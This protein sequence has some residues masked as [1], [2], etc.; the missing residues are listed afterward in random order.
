MAYLNQASAQ[1][2]SKGKAIAKVRIQW[3][4]GN[5]LPDA[6]EVR[7][8]ADSVT[9]PVL[10]ASV[11]VNKSAK[12]PAF[13]EFE[14]PAPNVLS[15][16]V[17]PRTLSNNVLNDKMPDDAGF[18]QY[19]E[20]F[21]VQLTPL[22]L[23]AEGSA[24]PEKPPAPLVLPFDDIGPTHIGVHWQ[25][26]YNFDS[27]FINITE[28]ALPGQPPNAPRT[29]HHGDDGEWGFQRVD[30]LKPKTTYLV[31]VQ[32]CTKSFFGLLSNNCWEWS[33]VV[34]CTTR[35]ASSFAVRPPAGA[36]LAASQQYGIDDQTDVFVVDGTGAVNVFWVNG[37]RPWNGPYAITAPGA[38]PVGAKVV[39]SPQ[40]GVHGQTDVFFVDNNGAVNVLWV[41]AGGSWKGPQAISPSGFAPAGAALAVSRQFGLDQTDVFAVGNNGAIHVLWATGG[42]AWN[43]PVPIS[44]AGFAP[45]GAQLAASKQ[46]G[47]EQTVVFVIGNSGAVHVLWAG[48]SGPWAGPAPISPAGF[49]PP[50]GALAASQQFGLDQT[51]VFVA[52]NAGAVNVLWAGGG[53]AW[54]GPAALSPAGF[55]S[56]GAGITASQQFGAGAQTDVFVVGNNGAL[57]VLWVGGGGAWNGPAPLTPGGFAPAGAALA[58]SKQ[59]G[60]EQLDVFLVDNAGTVNVSWVSSPEGW[61]GPAALHV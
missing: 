20:T 21:S 4:F 58:A 39:A 50:G 8:P 1:Q 18:E 49:A 16:V 60:S 37:G 59:H 27:Y 19:W 51:V 56:P 47:L 15:F 29:I 9:P 40:W 11:K 26:G 45:A 24:S 38:A 30:D 31:Q 44:P 22:A 14:V 57:N 61:K 5:Q 28:K 6:I 54:A 41:N 2:V 25:A 34:E 12:S 35:P 32:G 48:G 43:G 55:T 52:D 36:A 53:G 7:I 23:A 33:P 42:G 46:F 10:A 3:V 13:T 17:S